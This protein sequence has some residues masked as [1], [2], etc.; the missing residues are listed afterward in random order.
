MNVPFGNSCSLLTFDELNPGTLCLR[1]PLSGLY[2][3]TWA[4]KSSPLLLDLL[5]FHVLDV[6]EH[7][8]VR[9]LC[10]RRN[11]SENVGAREVLEPSRFDK[12]LSAKAVL[13]TNLSLAVVVLGGQLRVIGLKLWSGK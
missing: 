8:V 3:D 6:G 1:E 13:L 4:N 12:G 7:F 2:K 11:A 9:H 5:R 10:V